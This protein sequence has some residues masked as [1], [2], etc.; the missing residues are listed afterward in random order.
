MAFPPED[1][2]TFSNSPQGWSK[3][4]PR[5][6][7]PRFP[8]V[9]SCLLACKPGSGGL[10]CDIGGFGVIISPKLDSLRPIMV[11]VI[12]ILKLNKSRTQ[13]SPFLVQSLCNNRKDRN[14]RHPV[15]PGDYLD[16]LQPSASTDSDSAHWRLSP[17]LLTWHTIFE[18]IRIRS[19]TGPRI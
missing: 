5:T 6:V 10:E 2:C 18:Y 7:F 13:L 19:R 3:L 1:E 11:E 16:P 15:Y 14:S 12:M 17:S 8:Q 4:S 9:V